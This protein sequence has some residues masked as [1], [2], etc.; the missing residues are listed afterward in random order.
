MKKLNEWYGKQAG[1]V[2]FF[3]MFLG[4]TV[5]GTVLKNV[6]EKFHEWY[7]KQGTCTSLFVMLGITTPGLSL[8]VIFEGI[9]PKIIGICYLV[10]I[11]MNRVYYL[12]KGK[13]AKRKF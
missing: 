2:R 4:M 10:F 3:I 6:M 7:D 12:E 13:N 9:T 11:F 8:M 1:Y 5:L